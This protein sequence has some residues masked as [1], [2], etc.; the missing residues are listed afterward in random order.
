M[1]LPSVVAKKTLNKTS[2]LSSVEREAKVNKALKHVMHEIEG[3]SFF[4]TLTT[5]SKDSSRCSIRDSLCAIF[6]SIASSASSNFSI[7]CR[8]RENTIQDVS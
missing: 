2:K 1:R 4:Y 6:P 3:V 8:K 7:S 5:V